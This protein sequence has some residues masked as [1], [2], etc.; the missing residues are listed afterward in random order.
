MELA[1]CEL[2]QTTEDLS[3]RVDELSLAKTELESEVATLGE[4]FRHLQTTFDEQLTAEVSDMRGL[5]EDLED[6][7]REAKESL[8]LSTVDSYRRQKMLVSCEV[9]TMPEVTVAKMQNRPY[10]D[11]R[12]HHLEVGE[13]TAWVQSLKMWY[14]T[15]SNLAPKSRKQIKKE[16]DPDG[17]VS[18]DKGWHELG[19]KTL[20][21]LVRELQ[22]NKVF[23]FDDVVSPSTRR[24]KG[25]VK[26]KEVKKEPVLKEFR[27]EVEI[28]QTRGRQWLN[29]VET[30]INKLTTDISS[31][32]NKLSTDITTTAQSSAQKPKE[33]G[34]RIGEWWAKISKP[35]E[36]AMGAA[37]NA[38]AERTVDAA[39]G[40]AITFLTTKSKT[41]SFLTHEEA[42]ALSEYRNRAAAH[43]ALEK[44]RL[45]LTNSPSTSTRS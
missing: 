28:L 35:S 8:A 11:T 5:V 41:V 34:K 39:V 45:T 20:H 29:K 23:T 6:R 44:L 21:T 13:S 15:A 10:G 42:S 24:L 32:A 1:N 22:S 27:A 26:A 25:K 12:L 19:V 4:R 31:T 37:A 7:L 2:L 14:M 33:I 18:V 36:E 16:V 38:A 30:N 43:E 9:Q 17:S 3:G 40:Q